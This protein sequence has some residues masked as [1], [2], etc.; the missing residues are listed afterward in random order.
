[1]PLFSFKSFYIAQVLALSHARSFRGAV[2]NRSLVIGGGEAE[3][4]RHPYM[5][6]LQDDTSHFCGG[7]LI[8]PDVVLTAG[9]CPLHYTMNVYFSKSYAFTWQSFICHSAL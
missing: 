3:K 8:A 1:M 6:S 4:G 2:E 5:V 7:S 9:N